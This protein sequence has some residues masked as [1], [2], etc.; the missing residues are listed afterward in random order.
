MI[1]NMVTYVD[2]INSE[3]SNP[4]ERVTRKAT[5]PTGQP[6]SRRQTSLRRRIGLSSVDLDVINTKKVSLISPGFFI[7]QLL[8]RA[9]T[10]IISLFCGLLNITF[11]FIQHS[12]EISH[13]VAVLRSIQRAAAKDKPTASA[14]PSDVTH[15]SAG[16]RLRVERLNN[17]NL[18]SSLGPS[19]E[20]LGLGL[21]PFGLT[22]YGTYYPY[23]PGKLGKSF[24][25]SSSSGSHARTVGLNNKP[26]GINP[27][28][29]GQNR[30]NQNSSLGPCAEAEG[31][32]DKSIN[33]IKR[34]VDR[35]SDD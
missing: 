6:G 12:F 29:L 11:S 3:N 1:S 9:M 15:M 2:F 26:T 21:K 27:A 7:A 14:V 17:H 31:W 20:A 22:N 25:E 8:N 24:K 16:E 18:S 13:L 4:P 30:A 23:Y 5:D 32:I 35:E 33:G 19:A 10:S 28:T 34:K